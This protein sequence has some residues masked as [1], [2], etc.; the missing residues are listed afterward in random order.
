[1]P[2]V[3]VMWEAEVETGGSKAQDPIL[4]NKKQQKQK[5][6]KAKGLR[7]VLKW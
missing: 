1:M 5:T 6:L 2:D 7:V 4:K 3:P